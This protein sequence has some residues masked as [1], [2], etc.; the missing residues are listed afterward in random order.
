MSDNHTPK[1]EKGYGIS[2]EPVRF[3]PY[4]PT[5]LQFRKGIKGRWQ[6]MDEYCGWSNCSE[7]Y[8]VIDEVPD[9]NL[10][11]AAPELLEALEGCAKMIKEIYNSAENEGGVFNEVLNVIEIDADI[12][13]VEHQTITAIAKARGE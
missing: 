13:N 3:L 1:L 9:I 7:P 6:E 4:K 10:I 2:F 12:E 11:A 5:S 8:I